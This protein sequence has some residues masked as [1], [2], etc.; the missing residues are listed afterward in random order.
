MQDTPA[1][2]ELAFAVNAEPV[3]LEVAPAA[4]LLDVLRD[5]L[6]LTGGFWFGQVI[7][8][9]NYDGRVDLSDYQGFEACLSEPGGGVG[10]GCAFFDFDG[11]GDVD[12]KDFAELQ[13]AFTG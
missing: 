12:L 9:G 1:K 4:T 6:E 2:V 7:G 8:D 13:V 11:D 10:A 5:D 3:R